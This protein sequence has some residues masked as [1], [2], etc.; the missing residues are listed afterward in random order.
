MIYPEL[1][2]LFVLFSSLVCIFCIALTRYMFV[3]ANYC[4]DAVNIVQNQNKNSVSLRRMAE[5]ESTLTD[6]TD[7]YHALLKS[8]KTLRARISMRHSRDKPANGIDD[9]VPDSIKDPAGYKRA[10]RIQLRS[11]GLIK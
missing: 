5:V 8:H 4:R 6:V 1:S 10:M 3:L 7:S 2:T 9:T 11:K